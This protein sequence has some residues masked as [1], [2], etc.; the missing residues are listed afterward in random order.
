[1]KMSDTMITALATFGA[2]VLGAVVGGLIS[3]LLQGQ[4]LAATNVQQDSD[5]REV[6]KALALSLVFKMIRISSDLNNLGKSILDS[7]ERARKDGITGMPFQI[8]MPTLP[9]PDPI[10]F[11]PD[12]MAW[13]LSVNNNL[14]NEMGPLD[15]LHTSTVAIFDLYNAK[16]SHLLDRLGAEMKGMV[17]TT[18]LT[19]EQKLWFEPRAAELNQLVELMIQRSQRDTKEAWAAFDKLTAVVS[20]EFNMNLKFEKKPD[21]F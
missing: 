2:A 12:E 17:G 5:R 4:A 21:V 16:R 13:V 6:R 11:S 3:Y 15:E 20:R 18:T 8:V 19:H 10:R 1:M 9:L 7:M 14:F